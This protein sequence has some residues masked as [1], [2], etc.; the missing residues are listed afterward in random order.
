MRIANSRPRE[1][2]KIK[3][4]FIN[5]ILKEGDDFEKEKEQQ[6]LEFVFSYGA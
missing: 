2:Q 1:I 4:S 3:P 6:G 5:N